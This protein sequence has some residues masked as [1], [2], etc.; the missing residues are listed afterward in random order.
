MLLIRPGPRNPIG[1]HDWPYYGDSETPHVSR[2]SPDHGTDRAYKFATV[3][4]VNQAS[5]LRL[6][7]WR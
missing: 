4:I 3:C 2:T 7:G 5:D 1:V 6:G